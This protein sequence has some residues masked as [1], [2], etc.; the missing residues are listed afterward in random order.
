MYKI[1]QIEKE[2]EDLPNTKNIDTEYINTLLSGRVEIESPP[3]LR[4]RD[5]VHIYHQ[6]KWEKD[7]TLIHNKIDSIIATVDGDLN[8]KKMDKDDADVK[9]LST[10]KQI[11]DVNA[12]KLPWDRESKWY[13]YTIATFLTLTFFINIYNFPRLLARNSPFVAENELMAILFCITLSLSAIGYKFAEHQFEILRKY[14]STTTA[15][16]SIGVLTF[17]ATAIIT[18]LLSSFFTTHIVILVWSIPIKIGGLLEIITS[19]SIFFSELC[20]SMLF[21]KCLFEIID[22]HSRKDKDNPEYIKLKDI[23]KE[24]EDLLTTHKTATILRD[25]ITDLKATGLKNYTQRSDAYLL[26]QSIPTITIK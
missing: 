26:K 11:P 16:A 19:G 12:D 23:I 6:K 3:S 21:S 1:E 24:Y 20:T 2:I 8:K 9:I 5:E 18:F 22:A 4:I 14:S 10:Q 25:T 13:A 7:L 17:S 15:A